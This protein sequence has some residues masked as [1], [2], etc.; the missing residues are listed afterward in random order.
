MQGAVTGVVLG[1]EFVVFSAAIGLVRAYLLLDA[2]WQFSPELR[3]VRVTRRV[4]DSLDEA[5]LIDVDMRLVAVSAGLLVVGGYLDI[6]ARLD[7][8]VFSPSLL[9]GSAHQYS[10]GHKA[11]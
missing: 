4:V 10:L 2:G 11:Q 9:C 5:V 6:I 3:V 8:R 7:V 1:Q